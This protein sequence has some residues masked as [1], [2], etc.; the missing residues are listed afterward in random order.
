MRLGGLLAVAASLVASI[1]AG[2]DPS[3]IR[4]SIRRDDW[5]GALEQARRLAADRP[6]DPDVSTA[7]GEALYRAGRLDEADGVLGAVASRDDAPARALAT[8]AA[9]REAQGRAGEAEALGDRA[10]ASA[11]EDRDVLHRVAGLT[12]D[13]ARLRERL[14][15]YLERSGSDDPD[16]IEGAR[17][18]LRLYDA[19]GDRKVWVPARRPERVMIPLRSLAASPGR[20]AGYVVEATLAGGSRIRLLLDT[21]SSGLFVVER[22]VKKGGIEFLA[23][24]TVFAGGEGGR[25]ASKRGIL[26]EFALGELAFKDALVTTTSKDL[27][28]TGRFHGVLGLSIFDG[29]R[30][31]LDLAKPRL[32][33]EPVA[34]RDAAAAAGAGDAP[35]WLVSGQLLVAAE[36]DADHRGLFLLDTGAQRSMLA[37]AFAA[38]VPGATLGGE[39]SVRTYGG[40]VEGARV[41]RG[42][43]LRFLGL[44]STGAPMHVSDL[45]QRSRL[46]E[47]EVSGFLGLD[48]LAGR[49]IV[50][51]TVAR[52]V[53]VRAP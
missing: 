39:A 31:T 20:P 25:T 32:V 27:E 22:A 17:G 37:S 23:E 21:G 19:L 26:P 6:G 13:R 10:L 28:A 50:V 44:A 29:Y 7:L 18:T 46:A 52:R 30:V 35:Y 11:P 43:K 40:A 3:S 47:V 53:G 4:E 16:R 12:T 5:K 36:S 45:T 33:L 48:L 8:L 14:R 24:E 15:R 38:T 49:T 9:L 51:D 34:P 42:I 41:A 2:P 1:A